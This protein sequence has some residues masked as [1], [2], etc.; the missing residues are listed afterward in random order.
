MT[1]MVAPMATWPITTAPRIAM[2]AGF[3]ASAV[4]SQV[5]CGPEA[6]NVD[7]RSSESKIE[8]RHT[9]TWIFL[10]T[11]SKASVALAP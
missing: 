6:G 5:F 9:R 4:V 3:S 11:F 2:M 1:P 7:C 8:N 10:V